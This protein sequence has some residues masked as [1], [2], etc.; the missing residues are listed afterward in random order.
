MN[1]ITTITWATHE[2]WFNCCHER[3]DEDQLEETVFDMSCSS[4]TPNPPR[5]CEP[6][7]TLVELLAQ[8]LLIALRRDAPSL[9]QTDSGADFARQH[10]LGA[11]VRLSDVP[12]WERR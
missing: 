9:S 8:S 11:N 7:I 4:G 10:S 12:E 3:P 2:A 1:N 6:R 5:T